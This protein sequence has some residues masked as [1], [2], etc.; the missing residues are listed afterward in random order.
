MT[1]VSTTY[2]QT[3][4]LIMSSAVDKKIMEL[5][6]HLDV[7]EARQRRI[8]A[9]QEPLNPYKKL[10]KNQTTMKIPKTICELHNVIDACADYAKHEADD[11][12]RAVYLDEFYAI[13][14]ATWNSILDSG[15]FHDAIGK[16]IENRELEVEISTEY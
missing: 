2:G 14:S 13:I 10:H 7:L 5:R 9:A 4:E 16:V 1:K 12:Q 3:A 15:L 8:G 11:E 6:V